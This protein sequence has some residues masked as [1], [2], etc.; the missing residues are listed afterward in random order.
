MLLI[1]FATSLN[2]DHQSVVR[3]QIRALASQLR[4]NFITSWLGQNEGRN[5]KNRLNSQEL[6]DPLLN[7]LSGERLHMYRLHRGKEN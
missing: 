5:G 6:T 4:W 7:F 1:E 3:V 2:S